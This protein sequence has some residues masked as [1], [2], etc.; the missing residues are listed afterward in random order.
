MSLP[1]RF[2]DELRNRLSLS[3]I[4]GKRLRLQR[5]GREYKACCPFHR[6]K[7]P[8]FYVNDDK[9]FYHCF[10]C[11]AHGDVIGFVMQHDNLSFT[12]TVEMLAAEA[13][14]QVPKPSREEKQK[15]DKEKTLFA[16]MDA[17]ASFMQDALYSPRNRDALDYVL[18][19][20]ISEE[21]LSAFRIGYAPANGNE[22]R[23]FLSEKGFSD[24][25]M[26]EAGI[27]RPSTRGGDP[28]V[29]FR[30]RIMFPVPDRRGRI[31]AFGGRVLPDHLR[32]SARSES[33]PPKYLNSPDTFLF[34]KG[35]LLYGEPHARQAAA[36][37]HKLIVTEGYM[38]VIACHQAGF[39]GA[40]APLGTAL[41]DDQ[42]FRLWQL[43]PG[44]LKEPVLCFDGDAA[45]R[46]A[47]ERVM[48]KLLGLIK[49]GHSARF[50]FIPEGE[51]PD[52]LIKSRGKKALGSVLE[53]SMPLIDFMWSVKISGKPVET[54]EQK[55][56]LEKEM[57][58]DVA[59][60]AD[61]DLQY[62]YRT[63]LRTRLRELFWRMRK[64]EQRRHGRFSNDG[65]AQ[66]GYVTRI[67][68][69]LPARPELVHSILLA[70]LIN[71][72]HLIG[73]VEDELMALEIAS[74]GLLSLRERMLR[75]YGES[76]CVDRDMMRKALIGAGCQ[77][78]LDKLLCDNIYVHA[79]F[80]RS[81]TDDDKVIDGWR[82]MCAG[83][84][85]QAVRR[86]LASV[87]A[88]FKKEMSEDNQSR[89]LSLSRAHETSG[90]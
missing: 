24:A 75:I 58:Q 36:D 27:L 5:A 33:T 54:P 45:G 26:I 31:V 90:G 87:G 34:K 82:A 25:Q 86:E 71:H 61:R 18:G 77:E 53:A 8:S 48:E 72:P 40:L 2:L 19:R 74:Q 66:G 9:Q 32:P 81:S 11:G 37:G 47:A 51:D 1:P 73:E 10:G 6:E 3:D 57:E 85:G 35:S 20:G 21:T 23:S 80:A 14:M 88:H 76:D 7:T 70:A 16:L 55:T 79:G 13:G 12:E 62:H 38:D 68:K 52:S 44:D 4:A 46:R 59:R 30:E 63:T 89:L 67:R 43:V 39:K 29:F 78:T 65:Q 60:I 22:L 83:L 64:T 69:P 41:T 17:A 42:I 15:A 28:F 50:A 49:P 84:Y 56:A